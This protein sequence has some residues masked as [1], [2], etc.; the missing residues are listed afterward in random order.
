MDCK[1]GQIRI[2]EEDQSSLHLTGSD[3]PSRPG[4]HCWQG[5]SHL[6]N[7]TLDPAAT[8][9]DRDE[10]AKHLVVVFGKGPVYA[11]RGHL[12]GKRRQSRLRAT[13]GLFVTLKP[14]R[15]VLEQPSNDGQG[16]SR[17]SCEVEASKA[18]AV[19]E[20]AQDPID[21]FVHARSLLDLARPSELRTG[22]GSPRREE[23]G[24]RTRSRMSWPRWASR[25]RLAATWGREAVLDTGLGRAQRPR[26]T[27]I[28]GSRLAAPLVVER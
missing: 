28:R 7:L 20:R 21:P 15:L 27:P 17:L 9:R 19:A 16:F 10:T 14:L 5:G 1:A 3:Q 8:G 13:D 26:L 23:A 18:T 11:A 2:T 24:L 6:V 22:R 12:P 4:H 25:V